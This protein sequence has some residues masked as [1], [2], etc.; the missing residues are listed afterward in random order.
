MAER[1]IRTR[2]VLLNGSEY[3]KEV[4]DIRNELKALSATAQVAQKSV[5]QLN[6]TLNALF[7]LC[8]R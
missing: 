8:K 6:S 4:G 5:A 3:R 2:I 1:E 7:E